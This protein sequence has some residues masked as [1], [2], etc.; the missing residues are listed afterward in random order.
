MH[1]VSLD[2][3][4]SP[5]VLEPHYSP[6]FYAELWNVSEST[7]LRWFRDEPGVLRIG[8]SGAGNKRSRCEL[9]IPYSLAMR[10]YEER[11]R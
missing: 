8:D 3:T 11:T 1:D 4:K 2:K 6:R 9:R 7:T 10:V 5:L